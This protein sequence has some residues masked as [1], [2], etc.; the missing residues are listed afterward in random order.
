[1]LDDLKVRIKIFSLQA[2]HMMLIMIVG[3]TGVIGMARIKAE[4]KSANE[5]HTA[6]LVQLSGILDDVHQIQTLVSRAAGGYS[7][8]GQRTLS[9]EIAR[10]ESD[11]AHLWYD[12]V[13]TSIGPEE[14]AIVR[15]NEQ[16]W[17]AYAEAIHPA[18]GAP[19]EVASLQAVTLSS[20]AARPD[21]AGRALEAVRDGVRQLIAIQGHAADSSYAAA[22]RLF[23]KLGIFDLVLVCA[24]LG[25]AGLLMFWDFVRMRRRP[26]A[27]AAEVG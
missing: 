4:F 8:D 12:Y 19:V 27:R 7:E 6:A 17:R 21:D 9:A 14:E 22:N 18:P 3:V 25:L 23:M 11:R 5:N 24:G 16:A 26:A 15:R 2:F 13:A 20:P 10:L 1:M